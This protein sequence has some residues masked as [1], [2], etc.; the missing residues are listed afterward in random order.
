MDNHLVLLDAASPLLLIIPVLFLLHFTLTIFIEAA[1]LYSFRYKVFK[2][3]LVDALVVNLV[4]LVIGMVLTSEFKLSFNDRDFWVITLLFLVTF[5]FE[6]GL[7]RMMNRP[8]PLK[9]L[10]WVSLLMNSLTYLFLILIY[11]SLR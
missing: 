7:L 1:I 10:L 9:K 6:T 5:F 8:Y 11:L 4:S 3:S 2:R